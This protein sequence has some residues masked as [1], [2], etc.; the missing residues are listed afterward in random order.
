MAHASDGDEIYFVCRKCGYQT[1]SETEMGVHL[2]IEHN[3]IVKE[4]KK[5]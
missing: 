5:E 1:D 3:D 2:I 4:I